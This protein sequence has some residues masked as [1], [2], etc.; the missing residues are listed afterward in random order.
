MC[1]SASV[2]AANW[3]GKVLSRVFISRG[4]KVLLNIVSSSSN[5]SLF[6]NFPFSCMK[7]VMVRDQSGAVGRTSRASRSFLSDSCLPSVAFLSWR[8]WRTHRNR[9]YEVRSWSSRI[10]CQT[11]TAMDR[12]TQLAAFVTVSKH[13]TLNRP[14]SLSALWVRPVYTL[15]A[16]NNQPLSSCKHSGFECNK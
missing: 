4:Q 10:W 1:W 13:W 5:A 8:P 7:S 3:I 11:Q 12:I 14:E 15:A 2:L 16:E 6:F 9:W